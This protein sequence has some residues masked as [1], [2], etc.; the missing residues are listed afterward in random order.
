LSTELKQKERNLWTV[1]WVTR[2]CTMSFQFINALVGISSSCYCLYI[3]RKRN[4]QC[5]KFTSQSPVQLLYELR[6]FASVSKPKVV[7][8]C[9]WFRRTSEFNVSRLSFGIKLTVIN[10]I[11][12]F[13]ILP[14]WLPVCWPSIAA[15]WY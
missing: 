3:N 12:I 13:Q 14:L 11:P 2:N 5:F 7:R 1:S 9:F 6:N 15:F 10:R 8:Q 4:P